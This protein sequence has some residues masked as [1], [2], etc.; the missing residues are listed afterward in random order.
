MNWS[1]AECR[2]GD[3]IRVKIGSFYHYGIFKNENEVIQFGLPPAPQYFEARRENVTV[4]KTDIDTFACG[5]IVETAE[6]TKKEKKEKFPPEEAV[7]RAEARLGEGG[8]N[9]LHNN[10]EHFVYEV[11]FGKKL[12]T[13]EEEAKARWLKYKES[14]T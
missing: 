5:S 9:I 2:F 13:Q 12:S 14:N 6:F 7:S 3:M 10:C 8:Y 11:I 1:P 4:I